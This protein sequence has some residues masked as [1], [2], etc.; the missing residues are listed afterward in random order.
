LAA[1]CRQDILRAMH[2]AGHKDRAVYKSDVFIVPT[3]Q[4]NGTTVR[5]NRLPEQL[6]W[7]HASDV[8]AGKNKVR[9]TSDGHTCM[10]PF[11]LN[12]D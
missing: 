12:Q 7:L 9:I 2:A 1:E 11:F 8:T 4:L 3:H 5:G 10:L 6:E